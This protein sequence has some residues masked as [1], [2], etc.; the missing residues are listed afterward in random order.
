MSRNAVHFARAAFVPVPKKLVHTPRDVRRL[1]TPDVL[2]NH[3]FDCGSHAI[4]RASE[5]KVSKG[6]LGCAVI[7]QK[8]FEGTFVQNIYITS[9]ASEQAVDFITRMN[10][11]SARRVLPAFRHAYEM[12][13]HF[14]PVS[15]WGRDKHP[16]SRN[17]NA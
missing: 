1:L 3:E 16:W 5:F 9:R 7:R 13:I 17:S 4:V 8:T 12:N 14:S 10:S 11:M 6:A 2:D 15:S